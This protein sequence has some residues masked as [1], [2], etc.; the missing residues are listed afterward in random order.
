MSY[1]EPLRI[2]RTVLTH[3]E[4]REVMDA[5]EKACPDAFHFHHDIEGISRRYYIK[6]IG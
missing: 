6:P 4:L 5:V 2:V 1:N 3:E